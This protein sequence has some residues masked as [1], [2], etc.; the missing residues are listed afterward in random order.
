MGNNLPVRTTPLI[1][2]KP[3]FGPRRLGWGLVPMTPEGWA[4]LVAG[5]AGTVAVAAADRHYRWLALLVAAAMVALV[6]LKGTSPGG[7]AQWEELHSQRDDG[8]R[9]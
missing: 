5:V 2:K 3:W 6:F 7:P 4:V 9:D 8:A 1:G